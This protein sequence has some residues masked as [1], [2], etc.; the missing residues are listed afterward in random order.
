[1]H[2]LLTALSLSEVAEK[3][4]ASSWLSLVHK[5]QMIDTLNQL[6]N[7]TLFLPTNEAFKV[8]CS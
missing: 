8:A 3:V 1:M 6:R 5:A 4:G 2:C 7:Y